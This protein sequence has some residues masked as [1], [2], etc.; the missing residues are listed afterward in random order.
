MQ[1]YLCLSFFCCL[2]ILFYM[3][4]VVDLYFLL[5]LLILAIFYILSCITIIFDLYLSVMLIDI[6]FLL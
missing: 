5:Y 3:F 6:N 4:I 1:E 2:Q